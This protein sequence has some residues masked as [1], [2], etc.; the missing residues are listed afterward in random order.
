MTTPS[1]PDVA[2]SPASPC[3]AAVLEACN[4]NITKALLIGEFT[5]SAPEG[6]DMP[7]VTVDWTT[8]K[9]IQAAILEQVKINMGF[10]CEYCGNKDHIL[11]LR[12]RGKRS[13]CGHR[14]MMPTNDCKPVPGA[15]LDE[16]VR[17]LREAAYSVR[18]EID[19]C[20][21]HDRIRPD[22]TSRL[23]QIDSFLAKID[24]ETK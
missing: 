17:L 20:A 8:I 22:L 13:C 24:K 21:A 10:R 3:W 1:T 23:E 14:W 12:D 11:T 4:P 16:A 5:T 6:Y 7:G 18:F 2:G 19:E 15:K 9:E